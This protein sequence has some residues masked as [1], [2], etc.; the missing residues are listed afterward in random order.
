[1]ADAREGARSASP[2]LPLDLEVERVLD[3]DLSDG[4]GLEDASQARDAL[5]RSWRTATEF[6]RG[7]GLR[8][9]T[10]SVAI[11]AEGVAFA[12][13]EHADG[14]SEGLWISRHDPGEG[15]GAPMM[16]PR[17]PPGRVSSP[18]VAV[19][20]RGDAVLV[21]VRSGA[22]RRSVWTSCLVDGQEW[23]V[24]AQLTADPVTDA[25]M[26]C[27]AA[28]VGGAMVVVWRQFDRGMR[29][30][31][32]AS[33]HTP[34]LGWGPAV[35]LGDGGAGAA[36]DPQ[37]AMD[38]AGNAFVVWVT[39]SRSRGGVWGCRYQ[40]GLGWGEATLLNAGCVG[41]VQSLRVAC[42]PRGQA[43]AVWCQRC[44]DHGSVWSS[45]CSA[46]GSGWSGVELV[47]ADRAS[48]AIAAHVAANAKGEFMA[49]WTQGHGVTGTV[50]MNR[51]VGA[52]G[53]LIP[54]CIGMNP[55]RK[56]ADPCVALDDAGNALVVWT[57]RGITGSDIRSSR[58]TQ[59]RGW[60]PSTSLPGS[61]ADDHGAPHLIMDAHGNAVA[62]W[63]QA[64]TMGYSLWGSAYSS[65]VAMNAQREAGVQ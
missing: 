31:I 14:E 60:S 11:G 34:G 65:G 24:P 10:P 57:E 8:H 15:W 44:G 49:V 12:V 25:D 41:G 37:V 16:V 48:S 52:H 50:W 46:D 23:S 64:E 32:W 21:W 18:R 36:F 4:A 42:G 19:D 9:W 26:P 28:D 35:L 27:I 62:A 54:V 40:R 17:L 61:A 43:V 29:R 3:I 45:R 5:R 33:R 13:W 58:Y 6:V 22:G 7:R 38:A 59:A 20:A 1:M 63:M 47:G 53:W 39:A 51:F 55:L 2:D 56:A 30:N